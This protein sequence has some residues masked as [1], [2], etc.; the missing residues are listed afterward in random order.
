M[1]DERNLELQ[2]LGANARA[3]GRSQFDNPLLKPDAMPAVTGKSLEE[4]S[5]EEAAWSLGWHAENAMR[6]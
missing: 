1:T 6:P 4:W 2:R 5:A 3:Q